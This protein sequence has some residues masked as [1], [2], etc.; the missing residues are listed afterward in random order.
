MLSPLL[1]MC[2][3]KSQH[4]V[5]SLQQMQQSMHSLQIRQHAANSS[6]SASNGSAS[7]ANASNGNSRSRSFSASAIMDRALLDIFDEDER[8][9]EEWDELL[10]DRDYTEALDVARQAK[11]EVLEELRA[12]Y[13]YKTY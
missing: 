2:L 12:R 9:Q 8:V 3:K 6:S 4:S 5:Y 1:A 7:N 10:R 11:H 13:A